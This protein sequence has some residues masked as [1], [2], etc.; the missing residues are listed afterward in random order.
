MP[1]TATKIEA[2]A[3]KLIEKTY[4][5]APAVPGEH[6]YQSLATR[7]IHYN[8]SKFYANSGVN[9]PTKAAIRKWFDRD[10]P[11]WAIAI[12]SNI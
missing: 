2:I 3:N 5:N 7:V 9:P 12:L 10:C 8:L 1:Q 11:D 6:G 4:R